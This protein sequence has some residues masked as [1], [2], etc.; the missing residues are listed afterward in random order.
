ML[1]KNYCPC[2]K[3]ASASKTRSLCMKSQFI[4]NP[5]NTFCY[6]LLKI[7]KEYLCQPIPQFSTSFHLLTNYCLKKKITFLLNKFSLST[8]NLP[9]LYP[10]STNIRNDFQNFSFLFSFRSSFFFSSTEGHYNSVHSLRAIDIQTQLQPTTQK[11]I[12]H[13]TLFSKR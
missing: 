5:A 1:H 4:F 10:S 13:E 9:F 8:H 6:L 3:V 12:Y 2:F 11:F 7:S